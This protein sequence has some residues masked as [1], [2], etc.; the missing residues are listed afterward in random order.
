MIV[1]L[2]LLC[3]QIWLVLLAN[4]LGAGNGRAHVFFRFFNPFSFIALFYTLFFILPQLFGIFFDFQILGFETFAYDVRKETFLR[5]Q[6]HVTGFLAVLVLAQ[7]S[8]G[9]F[10]GNAGGARAPV[11]PVSV[12]PDRLSPVQSTVIWLLFLFGLAGVFALGAMFSNT[13]GFRSQLVK[14]FQGQVLTAISFFA[15]FAFTILL[16]S[17]ARA[18]RFLL[19]AV[20]TGVFAA[21]IL[22]TGS[23]GR[24]LWPLVLA[25]VL[26]VCK[27][28][29]FP[30]LR[31][32]IFALLCVAALSVM[33]PLRAALVNPGRYV[34]DIS[35]LE[36]IR[37][38]FI[39]RNFDGFS[40]FALMSMPGYITPSLDYLFS[41]ARNVFMNTYFA[42]IYRRGVGFG[43]TIPGWLYISGGWIG[44]YVFT[45][46]YGLFMSAIGTYM[47]QTRSF[48][49]Y[50]AY[51]TAMPWLSAVGGDLVESLDKLLI[52]LAPAGALWFAMLFLHADA[53]AAKPAR[54]RR[55]D[56]SRVGLAANPD[57]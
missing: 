6:F 10:V 48:V 28:D 19:C 57:R 24:L 8:F 12:I 37:M 29:E 39:K 25:F 17:L 14:S 53:P 42:D 50:A 43:S 47:R 3:L 52:A 35:L 23:R 4:R 49:I 16:F 26:F 30:A 40:N 2:L 33:D 31:I 54:G 34:T 51:L 5:T 32:A 20:I 11:D 38:L 22:M 41:G 9:A 27:R 7:I 21:G 55:A 36:S 18:R 56:A 13:I 45:F 46:C 44:F 1:S 15:N